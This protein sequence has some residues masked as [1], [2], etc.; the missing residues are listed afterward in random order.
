M[1]FQAPPTPAFPQPLAQAPSHTLA[2]PLAGGLAFP[3]PGCL[4]GPLSCRPF[5]SPAQNSSALL[6]TVL[7]GGSPG[8][9]PC[10]PPLLPIILF[11]SSLHP[12]PGILSQ[13]QTLLWGLLRPQDSLPHPA[14]VLQ[15]RVCLWMFLGPACPAWH[16]NCGAA[17]PGGLMP[18]ALQKTVPSAPR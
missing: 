11:S 15:A 13:S 10:S 18:T 9:T 3:T 6:P 8:L 5:H 7:S 16:L 14:S 17:W 4:I 1:C 2:S 12:P